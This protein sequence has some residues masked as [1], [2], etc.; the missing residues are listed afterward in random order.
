MQR[1]AALGVVDDLGLHVVDARRAPPR[2]RCARGSGPPRGRAAGRRAQY[3][4]T[5]SSVATLQSMSV[6][7]TWM[8]PL[9]PTMQLPAAVHRDHAEILDRRLGAVARAA[10]HRELDLVRVQLPQVIFSSFTP[11]AVL[12]PACRSGTIR[13]RRRSSPCAAPCRRRGRETMP[14]ALRSRHTAGRSSLLHPEQVDALAAGDLHLA[15]VV[16]VGHIGDGAQLLRRWSARPT[17][18]GRRN[19]CRPSGCWRASAR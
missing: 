12:N 13:S 2:G 14:A 1:A 9:P 7:R 8:P 17:C 15:D 5:S 19:R 11:I 16:L 4:S 3:S 10:G 18:A 6:A